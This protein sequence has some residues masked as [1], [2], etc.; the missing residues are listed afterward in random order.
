[1]LRSLLP[2]RLIVFVEE[3][4]VEPNIDASYLSAVENTLVGAVVV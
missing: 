1:M 3:V 2:N 4:V